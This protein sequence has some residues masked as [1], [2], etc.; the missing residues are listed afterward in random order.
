[1]EFLLKLKQKLYLS[2]PLTLLLISLIDFII[3]YTIHLFFWDND[4]LAYIS[5]FLG[6]FFEFSIPIFAAALLLIK[7]PTGKKLVLSSLCLALPRVIYSFPYY[8]LYYVYDVYDTKEAIFLSL[9]TN[10]ALVLIL[11]LKILLLYAVIRA[12]MKRAGESGA[13]LPLRPF[14]FENPAVFGIMIS[15]LIP[16]TIESG[17]EIYS[18]VSFFIENSKKYTTGD[19]IFYFGSFVFLIACLILS[20][21]LASLITNLVKKKTDKHLEKISTSE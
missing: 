12:L 9:V 20:G 10:L 3:F 18:T 7:A 5:H 19:I 4:V 11:A 1:M 6:R 16:F 8:Y 17:F 21:T 15:A 14:D 13:T 2:A